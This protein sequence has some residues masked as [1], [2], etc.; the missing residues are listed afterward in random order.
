MGV[1]LRFKGG[2]AKQWFS[3]ASGV[4]TRFFP[5]NLYFSPRLYP[6][7][8]LA[9]NICLCTPLQRKTLIYQ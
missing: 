4:K 6:R 2:G 8:G 5:E 7:F 3:L 9:V 1:Q